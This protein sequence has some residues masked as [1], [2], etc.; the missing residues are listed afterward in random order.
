VLDD[1]QDIDRVVVALDL[2]IS[3]V[4]AEP[5]V[6]ELY[7]RDA[8]T[9]KIERKRQLPSGVTT[10]FDVEAHPVSI[11]PIRVLSPARTRQPAEWARAGPLKNGLVRLPSRRKS[12]PAEGR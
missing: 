6:D 9:E 3:I 5:L 8:A 2:A 4:G 12:Q 7:N 10:G 1:A 11:Y